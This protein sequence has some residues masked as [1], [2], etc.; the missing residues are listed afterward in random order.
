VKLRTQ[1]LLLLFLL[2]LTPLLVSVSTSVPLVFEQLERFYY[3][4][5]LQ[6][7]RTDFSDLDQHITRRQEVVRLFAKFPE[8]GLNMNATNDEELEKVHDG[9]AAYTDWAN[10]VL[11]DQPDVSE[12]IFIDRNGELSFAL[13]RDI[14]TGILTPSSELPNLPPADFVTA[15]LKLRP[16]DVLTSPIVVDRESGVSAPDRFM[17]LRFIAPVFSIAPLSGNTEFNGAAVFNLDVGG[18]ASVYHGIY[19]VQNDGQYLSPE[20]DDTPTSTAFRDFPGLEAIF[21]RGKLALWQHDEQRIFW[22]PLFM[23]Q[24]SGPLWVGRSVDPSPIEDF[25]RKLEIRAVIIAAVLLLVVFV[26]ARI[27]AIRITRIST[28]LGDGIG[29]VLEHDEVVEF[30]WQ[31]PQELRSLGANLTRLSEKHAQDT[32]AMRSHARELE[33][34]NRYKS[35]FLANVSHELRTPLNSILLLSKMLAASDPPLSEEQSRQARV[36]QD[37]GKDLRALIDS[38]L[39]L[40]RIESR[41]ATLHIEQVNL[42]H[43]MQDL[44]DLMQPQFAEKKLDFRLVMEP[45]APESLTTDAEK[46]RQIVINFLSNALKFTDRGKVVLHLENSLGADR[47]DYP[48][49]ISV[50]DSGIGIPVSKQ[51]LVFEAFNQVDGS[52][53]RRYGGTGL[54]LA[55][56][57][58]LAGLIGGR[59]Q[60][61]S[62]EGTGST[63]SL[64]LPVSPQATQNAG[65]SPPA[66]TRKNA[67][68][69]GEE[70]SAVPAADYS[71]SRILLVDDDL[72]NL[73][74]LTPLLEHWNLEVVAAGDGTEA[75]E[76]L[77]NDP[78]FDLILMDLMMP[79]M[80]G[81]ETIQRIR[82]TPELAHLYIVALTARAAE[83]DRK[84]TLSSGA[85]EFLAKPVEPLHLKALLDRRIAGKITP[86]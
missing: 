39:D 60:L 51:E 34:S 18:L 13:D 37:A 33:E 66:A 28:E 30:N 10:R 85:D 20:D 48:L 49:S 65:A 38:I 14:K 17:T 32:R 74:A 2:G 9:R 42:R 43:L 19:W 35:E 61:K 77:H 54:G 62:Q 84:R 22:V 67:V 80:D 11:F 59:I 45:D 8:P 81:F 58:Q 53:S 68:Q 16:G 73:L 69:D 72:R 82:A 24:A 50:Q 71:G 23:T 21:A 26:I 29:R 7:L 46:L 41:K 56:S 83:D 64:L 79:E 27:I 78:D 63:F 5:Y 1:I 55:I 4:A 47:E 86:D 76:T 36:I 3:D 25:M 31:R 12:V 52:S 57:N 40:A 70:A 6:K 75:L 15:G 44:Y